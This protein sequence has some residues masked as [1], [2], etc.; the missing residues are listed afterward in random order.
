MFFSTFMPLLQCGFNVWVYIKHILMSRIGVNVDNL[1]YPMVTSD[2]ELKSANL[3][4][5]F[6]FNIIKTN[7]IC[8]TSFIVVCH[9]CKVWAVM[10]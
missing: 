1:I 3:V 6:G 7:K 8:L 9:C 4:S 2:C 10:M 5:F